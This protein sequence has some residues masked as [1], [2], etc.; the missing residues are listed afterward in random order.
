M[1]G[2]FK[3]TYDESH[4]TFRI[5]IIIVGCFV[6]AALIHYSFAPFT[7]TMAEKF[8]YTFQE[9]LWTFSIYLEAVAIL[10]QFFLLQRTQEVEALTADYVAC[11]GCYR[12]LYIFNWIWRA[13]HTVGY[14]DWIV[15]VSGF[16]QTALY[17]DFLYYYMDAKRKGKKLKLPS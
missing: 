15:W 8:I 3:H 4:D 7:G 9:L 5:Q 10:P 12:G 1:K 2:K 13:T 17:A 14:S 6:T 11:L 16:V